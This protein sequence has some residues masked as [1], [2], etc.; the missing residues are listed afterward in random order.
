MV[1]LN[2]RTVSGQIDRLA[3]DDNEILLADFKTGAPPVIAQD[4]PRAYW[5]QMALYRRLLCEIYPNRTLRALLIYT[6]G[7]PSIFELEN[8]KLD[9]MLEKL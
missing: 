7:S 1:G 9:E 5:L 3:V 8:E 2:F 6:R 4:I